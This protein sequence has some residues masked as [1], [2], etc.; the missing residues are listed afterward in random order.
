[1]TQE[2]CDIWSLGVCG[3]E[4]LGF[5]HDLGVEPHDYVAIVEKRMKKSVLARSIAVSTMVIINPALRVV[6]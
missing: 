6:V 3:I 5:G 1:M 4:L 2:A